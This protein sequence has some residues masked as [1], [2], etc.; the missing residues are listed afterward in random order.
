MSQDGPGAR[1]ESLRFCDR[2]R[3]LT[4]PRA[5]N[6]HALGEIAV[7][8]GRGVLRRLDH[9]FRAFLRHVRAGGAQGCLRFRHV[10][11]CVT[12]GMVCPHNG[13]VRLRQGSHSIRIHGFLQLRACSAQPLQ[14]D[15]PL[16]AVRLTRRGRRREPALLLEVERKPLASSGLA[17]GHPHAH[18]LLGRN[19]LPA[20]PARLGREAQAAAGVV[21]L[22]AG[23]PQSPQSKGGAGRAF[24]QG[25]RAGTEVM[26]PGDRRDHPLARTDRG[27]AA[28]NP[29]HDADG[30]E[31]GR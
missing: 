12:I 2:C 11:R 3:W 20:W 7:A 4:R 15:T 6:E 17:R 19:P 13:M 29:E 27:R 28:E 18:D 21:A 24:A 26:S 23:Q 10:S 9:A 1:R 31:H 25:V 5:A 16:K 14:V 8:A 22:P 30:Q